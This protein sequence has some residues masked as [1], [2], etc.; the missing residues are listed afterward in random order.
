MVVVSNL[1][2]KNIVLSNCL[3]ETREA[4]I[5]AVGFFEIFAKYIIK[6]IDCDFLASC[7]YE[8]S[9]RNKCKDKTLSN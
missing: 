7:F 1:L 9:L 6:L 8:D 2:E 3:A 4:A 5:Q